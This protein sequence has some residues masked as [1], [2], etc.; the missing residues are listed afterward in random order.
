MVQL[1]EGNVDIV[2]QVRHFD[3]QNSVRRHNRGVEKRGAGV[4]VCSNSGE[5][6]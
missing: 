2:M 4:A 6:M 5:G 1:I 3:V